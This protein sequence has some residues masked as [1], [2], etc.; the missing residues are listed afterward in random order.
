MRKVFFLGVFFLGV[1][2]IGVPEKPQG[3]LGRFR[4]LWL[5]FTPDNKL[6]GA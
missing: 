5:Y 3:F 4:N 1:F 2:F 6:Y